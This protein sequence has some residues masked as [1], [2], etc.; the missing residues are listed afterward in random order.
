M[1]ILPG[2][3]LL[4]LAGNACF[5]TTIWAADVAVP[6]VPNFHQVNE[7]VYRGAQPRAEGWSS[8]AKLGIKTV[9]DL[10]EEVGI[11]CNPSKRRWRRPECIMS[12]CHSAGWRAVA[13]KG[14]A[15]ARFA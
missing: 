1:R 6:G 15:G 13:I 14:L 2:V 7:R 5:S 4:V 12:T 9:I 8:L 3:A 11:P 10:R